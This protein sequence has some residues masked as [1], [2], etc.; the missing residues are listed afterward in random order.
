MSSSVQRAAAVQSLTPAI[1]QAQRCCN[2]TRRWRMRRWGLQRHHI[3]V[4]DESVVDVEC[5]RRTPALSWQ[6][7]QTCSTRSRTV[8][9][10]LKHW[11]QALT[12]TFYLSFYFWFSNWNKK[13]CYTAQLTAGPWLVSLK[14]NVRNRH[15][16][17]CGIYPVD[18]GSFYFD[19]CFTHG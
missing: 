14:K 18:A 4:N 15:C 6:Y 16:L 5:I 1:Q 11:Q 19:W 12:A 2:P 17:F 7:E 3:Q 9:P 13:L 10:S 8:L